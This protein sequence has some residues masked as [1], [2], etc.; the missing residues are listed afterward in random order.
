VPCCKECP[1]AIVRSFDCG[2]GVIRFE[3]TCNTTRI[4]STSYYDSS[5]KTTAVVAAADGTVETV[6]LT[7]APKCT[8]RT[9]LATTVAMCSPTAPV[10]AAGASFYT[11]PV[12]RN[13]EQ[14]PA[15]PP[16]K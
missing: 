7:A 13:E 16:L 2:A 1:T 10:V 6:A 9:A 4:V 14:A 5:V 12:T 11:D 15:V 8:A 3:T